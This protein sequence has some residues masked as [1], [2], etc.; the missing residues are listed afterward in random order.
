MAVGG[1][2]I[3]GCEFS[4]QQQVWV[5]G[6]R[7]SVARAGSSGGGASPAVPVGALVAQCYAMFLCSWDDGMYIYGVNTAN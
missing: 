3:N 5:P 1:V 2:N 4:G 6:Q 7:L